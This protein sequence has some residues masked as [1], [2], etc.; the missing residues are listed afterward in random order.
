M[1]SFA[2]LVDSL[3]EEYQDSKA[4]NAYRPKPGWSWKTT[5]EQP[6]PDHWIL[7]VRTHPAYWYTTN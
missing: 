4:S 3:Q 2:T 6:S 5:F 7:S 1:N